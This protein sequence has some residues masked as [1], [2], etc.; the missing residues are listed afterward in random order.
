VL[1]VGAFDNVVID[2]T[3]GVSVAPLVPSLT[4]AFHALERN[5]CLARGQQLTG[6]KLV[7][8]RLQVPCRRTAPRARADRAG[9]DARVHRRAAR[10]RRFASSSR[11]SPSTSACRSPQLD[12]VYRV[13][14]ARTA[15]CDAAD[16]SEERGFRR[17]ARARERARLARHRRR[18]S[19]RDKGLSV[20]DARQPTAGA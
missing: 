10:Q 5:G 12:G 20:S 3:T 17:R 18:D 15:V 19:P 7:I 2:R 13:L 9:G 16:M 11:C 8:V 4:E 14:H 1:V 6:V